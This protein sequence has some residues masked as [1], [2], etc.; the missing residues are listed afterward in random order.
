M[1]VIVVLY[2]GDCCPSCMRLLFTANA[3]YSP[4]QIPPYGTIT[5]SLSR[6][7]PAEQVFEAALCV[8]QVGVGVQH[9]EHLLGV[10]SLLQDPPRVP[11]GGGRE[12]VMRVK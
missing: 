9:V 8:A 10:D 3:L 4:R 1:D 11:L 7:S 2:G 12:R 6:V 5:L